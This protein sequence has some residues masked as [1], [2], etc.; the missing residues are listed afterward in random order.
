MVEFGKC[1]TSHVPGV[2]CHV[3]RVQCGG[4]SAGMQIYGDQ[5][6]TRFL[7]SHEY[8]IFYT[9]NTTLE[10]IVCRYSLSGLYVYLAFTTSHFNAFY[11]NV[12]MG[13]VKLKAL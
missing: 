2:T 6:K 7:H 9:L 13:K 5:R 4:N 8:F 12:K 1:A 3:A 11:T 10:Y